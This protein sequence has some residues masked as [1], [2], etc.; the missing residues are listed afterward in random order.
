M[1]FTDLSGTTCALGR[2]YK[3]KVWYSATDKVRWE[4]RNHDWSKK[5]LQQNSRY[6]V[7]VIAKGGFI[8][9]SRS[10][11]LNLQL[12]LQIKFNLSMQSSEST[13]YWLTQ[14]S[15]KFPGQN[16]DLFFWINKVS[17]VSFSN[18]EQAC[19]RC[20]GLHAAW[21]LSLGSYHTET[22]HYS[23][24]LVLIKIIIVKFLL[25]IT[26][27]KIQIDYLGIKRPRKRPTDR[28]LQQALHI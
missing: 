24:L 7:K 16:T 14:S 19:L 13:R 3:H 18:S 5:W 20:A 1:Y 8:S 10:K 4:N 26:T 12:Q 23:P 25:K 17:D 28:S 9:A 21:H 27:L 15:R 22:H 2:N 11:E 6:A